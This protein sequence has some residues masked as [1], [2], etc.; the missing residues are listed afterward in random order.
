MIVIKAISPSPP[1][2]PHPTVRLGF[3]DLREI[4]LEFKLMLLLHGE[5]QGT[6]R[7]TQPFMVVVRP[8]DIYAN[9]LAHAQQ[10]IDFH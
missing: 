6:P 1:P 4:D 5:A 9:C 2:S 10:I 7:K 8:G 3:P